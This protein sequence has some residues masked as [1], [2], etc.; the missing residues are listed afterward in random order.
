MFS[1]KFVSAVSGKSKNNGAD[2]Y[3]VDLVAQTGEGGNVNLSNF[4]NA[5]VYR[6]ALN[7]APFEDVVVSV[8]V[9]SS[10]H[11][12]VAGMKKRMGGDVK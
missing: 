1:A 10:G 9:S 12:E 7:F 11:F 4:V 8:G 6:E 2:W 5:R 3:R